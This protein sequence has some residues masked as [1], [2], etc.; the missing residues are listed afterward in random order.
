MAYYNNP[1][2]NNK[3]LYDFYYKYKPVIMGARTTND[4][5]FIINKLDINQKF[6]NILLN[7]INGINYPNILDNTEF[8][9]TFAEINNIKYKED[10]YE[11]I[12]KIMLRKTND[13]AQIKCLTRKANKKP[14][15]PQYILLKDIYK[16]VN[17]TIDKSCP[18]CNHICKGT[19]ATDY[20][21]CGYGENGYDWEGC[22]KDWCFRC[23]K[24][25][26]KSWDIDQLYIQENRLHDSE[27]C[28]K[29]ATDKKK[30]YLSEYCQCNNTA[31]K[32][33]VC[34]IR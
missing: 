21:I 11:F 20:M 6:R 25:L 22:G 34:L 17:T 19:E 5:I 33:N 28:K 10:A 9:E 2:I 7:L 1:I 15:K 29:Q 8:I 31:V 26:C 4:A 13:L 14:L 18:Y 16:P 32:R 24:L 3:E 12:N 27:C 30:N 23:D